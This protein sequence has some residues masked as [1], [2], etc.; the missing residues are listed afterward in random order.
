MVLSLDERLYLWINGLSGWGPLDR[1]MAFLVNDYFVPVCL[2]LVLFAMWFSGDGAERRRELQCAVLRS[3][4]GIGIASIVVKVSNLLFYRARPFTYLEAN[5]LFYPPH[6]SSFPSNSAAIAFAAAFGIWLGHRKT[7]MVA[8]VVAAMYGFSRVYSGIHFPLDIA[9]GVAYGLAA[10]LAAYVIF[11]A[12]PV[13][14]GAVI[15]LMRT[16]HLA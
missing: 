13:L 8:L 3:M 16:L 1:V 7:G 12:L 2:S 6:D 5:L 11:K 10:T 14:P 15:R 9:G 4:A